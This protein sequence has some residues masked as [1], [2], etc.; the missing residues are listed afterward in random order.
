[1]PFLLGLGVFLT[2]DLWQRSGDRKTLILAGLLAGMSMGSKY[3]G[4][5][6]LLSGIAAILVHHR[7][8]WKR[9]LLAIFTFGAAAV[10]I[11][12]PWLVK[13]AL[14]TGNPFYPFFFEAGAMTPVRLQVYQSIETYGNWLDILFLPIRATIE[15]RAFSHGYDFSAGALLLGLGGLSILARKKL[16]EA[17]RPTFR[18]AVAL[19]LAGS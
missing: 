13:N 11:F 15:G 19:S 6:I 9:S 12:S 16:P 3:T 14:T 10:L 17:A 2:L 8:D 1:M 18:L 4:G 7:K 5:V